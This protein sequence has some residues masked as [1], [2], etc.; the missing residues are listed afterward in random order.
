M[1]WFGKELQDSTIVETVSPAAEARARNLVQ[2]KYPLAFYDA[3]EHN[4]LCPSEGGMIRF[5]ATWEAAWNYVK[6]W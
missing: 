2:H 1:T 4:V 6:G 3:E 5:G